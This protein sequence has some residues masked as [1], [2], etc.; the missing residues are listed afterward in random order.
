[1]FPSSDSYED[2]SMDEYTSP[3]VLTKKDKSTLGV[4]AICGARPTGINFDVLTCSSCKAFFRRNGVKPL[5]QFI[6][7]LSGNCKID[8]R[9]RRQCAACRLN[10]CFAMGMIKERI[11]SEEQNQRHRALVEENRRQKLKKFRQQHEK[12]RLKPSEERRRLFAFNSTS[13]SSSSSSSL[14][15]CSLSLNDADYIF[16]LLIENIQN[17][18]P[19]N[20]HLIFDHDLT[21][22]LNDFCTPLTCLITFFKQLHSFQQLPVDDRLLLLKTNMKILLPIVIHLFNTVFGVQIFTKQPGLYNINRKISY[23]CSLIAYNIPDDNKFLTLFLVVILFCPCLFTTD[24]LCDAGQMNSNS[25]QFIRNIYDE[26]IHLLWL[27]LVEKSRNDE[28]QAILNYMKIVTTLLR[29]QTL[30]SEVY[31]IVQCSVQ[32]DRLHMMM[33]SI[34]HLS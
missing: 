18:L 30:M 28:Q 34:L 19:M 6:C 7:R 14:S 25:R 17:I 4:C 32:I 21:Q 26:Y 23:A 20:C 16:D 5:Y 9:S 11:R 31:S 3:G 29:V 13:V 15:I 24:L 10:K 8:E 2:I 12:N 1:M 22:V 33:Q 27:Y